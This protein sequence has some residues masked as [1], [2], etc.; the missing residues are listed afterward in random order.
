MEETHYSLSL[1]LIVI[2]ISDKNKK[3]PEDC[4]KLIITGRLEKEV[5]GSGGVSEAGS[6][7]KPSPRPG[8]ASGKHNLEGRDSSH[9]LLSFSLYWSPPLFSQPCSCPPLPTVPERVLGE[10]VG[11]VIRSHKS[12]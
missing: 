5:N 10:K 6:A 7:E 12:L 1:S 4:E 3:L 2:K 11:E 9:H 8:D